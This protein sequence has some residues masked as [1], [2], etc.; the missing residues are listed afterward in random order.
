MLIEVVERRP[1]QRAELTV[2]APRLGFQL[3]TNI[4]IGLHISARGRRNLRIADF[5]AMFREVFQQRFIR[6]ETLRQPFRIV[7][8]LTGNDIFRIAQFAFHRRHFG[9]QRTFGH[10]FDAV[11]LDTDRIDLG[12][13]GIAEGAVLLLAFILQLRQLAQTVEESH[14]IRFRLETQQIVFAQHL[15]QLF[16][17]RQR[18]ENF[19]RWERNV[20]EEA[21]AVINALLTQRSS[22]RQQMIIVDPQGVVRLNQRLQALCQHLVDAAVTVPGFALELHQIETVVERGPDYGI[23]EL[24]V[25]EI[26]IVLAQRQRGVGDAVMFCLYKFVFLFSGKFADFPVPAKPQSSGGFERVKN[27]DGEAACAGFFPIR[28]GYSVRYDH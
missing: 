2:D 17:R 13:K 8:A 1:A 4:L 12:H 20:Q 10:L 27:A 26:V 7:E 24:T 18:V 23:G 15:E 19:R 6:Q 3:M 11:R 9:R 16:M 14:T 25:V 28:N 5:A 22:E 21:N